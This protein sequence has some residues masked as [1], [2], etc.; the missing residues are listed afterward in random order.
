MIERQN[1]SHRTE[2]ETSPGY[3]EWWYMH[4]ITDSG[5]AINV[6][7]HETD[8]FGLSKTPYVSLSILSPN[9]EPRHYRSAI[10]QTEGMIIEKDGIV[11]FNFSFE[12]DFSFSGQAT[13][14]SEPTLINNGVLYQDGVSEATSNWVANLPHASFEAKIFDNGQTRECTGVAYQD[15]QWGSER[16][17]DFVADWVWG[18]FSGKDKS[19][20][21]FKIVTQDKQIIDR[22]LLIGKDGIITDDKFMVSHLHELR[23]SRCVEDTKTVVQLTSELIADARFQ[24]NPINLMRQRVG[25]QLDGFEATYLRWASTVEI[26]G[27]ELVGIT[28]YIRIRRD[29]EL[30]EKSQK[31]KDSILLLGG[32]AGAGKTTLAEYLS[33]HAGLVHIDLKCIYDL[34]SKSLGYER[35][36]DMIA[37]V[38]DSIFIDKVLE[39]VIKQIKQAGGKGVVVDGVLGTE[40]V[41]K[42]KKE[43]P[44]HQI[45]IADISANPMLRTVR[46]ARRQ[47]LSSSEAIDERGFRDNFLARSGVNQVIQNAD[48]QIVNEGPLGE[49]VRKVE[50]E[51]LRR[52]VI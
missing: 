17:Q 3:F 19:V 44:E 23:A 35:T 41:V 13:R 42:V 45:I 26:E 30:Q 21:F 18:H 4:F 9:Q 7:V 31:N 33:S 22:F 43:F 15:H 10:K 40:M 39:Q 20:I 11:N 46:I 49:T 48:F 36:R 28:E 25:E 27:E 38:G 5:E 16:I 6:V 37:E 51:L 32:M 47:D 34:I 24:L 52:T 29:S 12:D 1:N 2:L 14:L 50:E 8:I